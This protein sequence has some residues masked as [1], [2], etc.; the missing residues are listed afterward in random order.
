MGTARRGLGRVLALVLV[1]SG[2][3]FVEAGVWVRRLRH[4]KL[5]GPALAGRAKVTSEFGWRGGKHH[6]GIDLGAR[7]GTP[8]LAVEDGEVTFAGWR[9]GYG[10]CVD[11]RHSDGRST[12]YAHLQARPPVHRGLWIPIGRRVGNVGSSGNATGPHL[13]LEV[14]D[15]AGRALQ[16]RSHLAPDTFP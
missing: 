4:G 1:G 11:L 3:A 13:H 16:P 6:D 2:P 15:A 14:R 8:V 9:K 10:W 7:R 12:R 5:P